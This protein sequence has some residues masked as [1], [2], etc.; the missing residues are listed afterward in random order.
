L[1][2]GSV[3]IEGTFGSGDRLWKIYADGAGALAGQGKSSLSM[4]L[5]QVV[6]VVDSFAPSGNGRAKQAYVEERQAVGDG[7]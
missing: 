4:A 1:D 3:L 5:Y 6:V 7:Y 2:V